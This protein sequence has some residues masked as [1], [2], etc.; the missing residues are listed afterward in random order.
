M[1][2]TVDD[3]ASI[4]VLLVTETGGIGMGAGTAGEV[5]PNRGVAFACLGT[6]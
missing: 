2:C 4:G 5:E 6:H 1:W 3:G